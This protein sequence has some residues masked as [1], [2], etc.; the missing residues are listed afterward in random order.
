MKP[1]R[2]PVAGALE[3]SSSPSI[4]ASG[5]RSQCGFRWAVC[6][7]YDLVVQCDADGQHRA[8]EIARL[9][10]VRLTTGADLVVGTRFKAGEGWPARGPRLWAMHLLAWLATRATH[11]EVSDATSGFRC[12][13]RPLLDEFA[14]NYPAQYLGD[15]FEALV[16][17]GRAGYRISEVPVSM[18]S[19]RAGVSSANSVAAIRYLV[20]AVIVTT[21]RIHFTVAPASGGAPSVSSSCAD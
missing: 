2:R 19:R 7:G 8:V 16:A 1:P 18:D 11:T 10:E 21:F 4:S 5:A 20:R 14:R 12:I 9:V 13:A 15:T 6:H 3:C 17:A